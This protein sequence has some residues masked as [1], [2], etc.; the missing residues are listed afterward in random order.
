M[1]PPL[2]N[3]RKTTGLERVTLAAL[4]LQFVALLWAIWHGH[5]E[6]KS[7]D[8][9]DAAIEQIVEHV[10][11]EVSGHAAVAARPAVKP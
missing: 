3:R 2:P 4:L 1:L 6:I 7:L 9:R 11:S 10:D 5:R 8:V